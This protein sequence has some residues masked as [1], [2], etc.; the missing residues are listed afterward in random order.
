M[1]Y[2]P[3]LTRALRYGG[4]LTLAIAVVGSIIGWLV[5]GQAG[6]VSA[7]IG[8]GITAIFMAF[9]A[10]S[11]MIASKVARTEESV[12]LFFGII[13]GSWLLKFVV[14]I[15]LM[16]VLREQPFIDP[17]IMF[18]SILAAVIGSLVVD[19]LAYV[20]SRVPYVDVE[21]PGE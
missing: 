15:F 14:F 17:I 13:L 20:R 18:V 3:I 9:T 4:I 21:L 5:A 11:I 7:L 2:S 6:L 19:V 1:T 16:V 12:M 10:V 8:A